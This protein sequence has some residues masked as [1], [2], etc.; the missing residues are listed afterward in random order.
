MLAEV[1]EAIGWVLNVGWKVR[2]LSAKPLLFARKR[3]SSPI[4]T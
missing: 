3:I 2:P 1:A 4:R